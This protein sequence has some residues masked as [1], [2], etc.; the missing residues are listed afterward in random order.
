MGRGGTDVIDPPEGYE[1]RSLHST[2]SRGYTVHRISGGLVAVIDWIY[3]EEHY[4]ARIIGGNT[5][6][7]DDVLSEL[8][9]KVCAYNRLMGEKMGGEE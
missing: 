1:F 5:C 2:T 9:L 6:F 8:V 3:A 7:T 4:I